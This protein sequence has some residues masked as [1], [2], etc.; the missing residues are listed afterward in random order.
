MTTLVRTKL[1]GDTVVGSHRFYFALTRTLHELRRIERAING[2]G[3]ASCYLPTAS[4]KKAKTGAVYSVWKLPGRNI[5]CHRL[6]CEAFN[7][8]AFAMAEP[9][10]IAVKPY[11]HHR[12]KLVNEFL[13]ME[14][15]RKHKRPG[16]KRPARD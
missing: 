5:V 3:F 12:E 15:G 2:A 16:R 8:V 14:A 10:R 11:M 6:I 13:N 1:R 9:G 7:A 4:R